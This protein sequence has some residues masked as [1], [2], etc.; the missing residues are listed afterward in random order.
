MPEQNTIIDAILHQG[1]LPLFYHEDPA[2]CGQVVQALYDG[3]VRIIEFTNRGPNALSNFSQLVQW[4]NEKWPGLLLAIGTIKTKTDASTYINAGADFIICPGTVKEVGKTV[5]NAGKL[6]IPGCMTVSEIL[7]AQA[8]GARFIK[9]FPGN[10]LGPSFMAGIRDIFP[11]LYFMPTG[12][13]ELTPENLQ[14]WFESGVAAVGLG[15]KFLSKTVLEKRDYSAITESTVAA[16]AMIAAAKQS[17][18]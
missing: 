14:Q 7:L 13:V 5:L 6:W 1:M 8:T 4:R 17:T 11:E 18:R 16:L 9:L 3:G 2:N 15:S 12:G 10:L